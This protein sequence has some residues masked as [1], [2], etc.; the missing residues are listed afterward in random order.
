MD[1][2]TFFK[3]PA[4]IIVLTFL[5]LGLSG[6]YYFIK[7][8]QEIKQFDEENKLMDPKLALLLSVPTFGIYIVYYVYKLGRV[9][10]QKLNQ[11]NLANQLVFVLSFIFSTVMFRN[12][13]VLI[14]NY[15]AVAIWV[16]IV[17]NYATI[18]FRSAMNGKLIVAFN[19]LE[20]IETAKKL[21]IIFVLIEAIK[22]FII[23]FK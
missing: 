19:D 13:Y 2:K 12:L 15:V 7:T 16:L 11:R 8:A 10:E 1:I 5:T 6:V 18:N 4:G 14:P 17:V 23:M 9:L 22:T 21:L 20:W 3:S